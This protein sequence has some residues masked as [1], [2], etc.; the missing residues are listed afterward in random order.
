M[1]LLLLVLFTGFFNFNSIKAQVVNE[2]IDLQS[3]PTMHMLF[4][5][6]GE[7]L[8]YFEE[9]NEPNLTY[10][11]QLKNVNYANYLKDNK[12]ARIVVFG[13][14]TKDGVK[15]EK[16]KA[17]ILEQIDFINAF[18]E[19]NPADFALAKSPQQVRHLVHNTDK[20]IIIHSIEGA[21]HLVNNQADA[22]F[23]AEQGVAF[24]TLIHL[25]DNELGASAIRPG[26][27]IALINFKGAIRKK[28]KRGGLT[29]K[30]KQVIL[31]LANAGIMTDITHMAEQ[32]RIDALA[33]MEE[34][35]IPPIS[36]HDAY[37]PIQNSPRGISP[38][39]V[40]SIYKNKGFVSLPLSGL[41]LKAYKSEQWVLDRLNS[42]DNYCDG[43]IDSYKFTYQL[44]KEQIESNF[45]KIDGSLADY[46]N[47]N[48]LSEAQKVWFSI[49]FQSDFNGWVSHSRP[50]YGKDGCYPLNDLKTNYELE[51]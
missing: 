36:T 13:S 30:G 46:Q 3:H 12:G 37:K 15:A 40:L 8:Q 51:T 7:G 22:N 39:Q 29:E 42:L 31:W 34:N 32:T 44:L 41:S 14:L 26:L 28:E 43:S 19:R 45:M 5:F 4:N 6:F 20:T 33:F 21:N 38:E 48:E 11:H 25:V 24:F 49:G 47:F 17:V 2:Y 27:G 10:K 23:W 50:R 1:R 18:I 16:A 35:G 9:G